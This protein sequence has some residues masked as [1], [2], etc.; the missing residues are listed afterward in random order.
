MDIGSFRRFKVEYR[1]SLLWSAHSASLKGNS[2]DL[3]QKV[4]NNSNIATILINTYW[5]VP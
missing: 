1:P 4:N 5:V 2:T 3:D